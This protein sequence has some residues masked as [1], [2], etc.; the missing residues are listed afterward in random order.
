LDEVHLGVQAAL[1]LLAHQAKMLYQDE[2]AIRC[3]SANAAPLLEIRK[4]TDFELALLAISRGW[5]IC[6]EIFLVG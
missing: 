1:M 6:V 4:N 3:N 2:F 5:R